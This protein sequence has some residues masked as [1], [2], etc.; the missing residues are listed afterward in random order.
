MKEFSNQEQPPSTEDKI[1]DLEMKLAEAQERLIQAL[2]KEQAEL[3]EE[4][5]GKDNKN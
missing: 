3:K 4:I 1:K 2:K 5:E